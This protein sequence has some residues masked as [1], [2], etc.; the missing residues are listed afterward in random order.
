[1]KRLSVKDRANLAVTEDSPTPTTPPF[2][3]VL[4]S[5]KTGPGSMMAFMV[6]KS[7]V[8]AQN[9]KLE[10]RLA[11]FQDASPTRLIDP[12]LIVRSKWANRLEQSFSDA[13]FLSL[14]AEIAS[15]GGNVQP[16][17]VRPLAGEGGKFEIVFGHRRHQACVDLGIP[18][19]AMVSEVSESDL[20]AE[21]DRENRDRKDLRPYEQGLTYKRALDEGLFSSANKMA[22][23]LGVDVGNLSKSL[24]L[25]RLPADVLNAFSSPLDILLRW[26]SDLRR[27]LEKEPELVLVRAQELQQQDPRP[28]PKLVLA[29][30]TNG[31]VVP[32]NPPPQ[33][34]VVV[35]GASGQSGAIRLNAAA[36]SAVI[37]LKN[38]DPTK[39][40]QLEK[41]IE[42]F[43][44]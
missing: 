3:P 23:S 10:A 44:S 14:K 28:A 24:A 29:Y 1:M 12:V 34:R 19:L 25:A 9:I 38:V 6:Q 41:L 36:R 37:S 2:D 30:L 13:D 40:G 5:P 8:H 7:D 27:V 20:F 32:N 31:G 11:E 42:T 21:M 22:A 43:L 4:G 33:K 15:A 26:A 35:K 39:L 17:K 18:V 16:I